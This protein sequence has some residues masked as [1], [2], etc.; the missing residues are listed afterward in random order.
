MASAKPYSQDASLHFSEGEI[1]KMAQVLERS[2]GFQ[3][4]HIADYFA[5]E[6]DIMGDFTRSQAWSDV[7]T[8]LRGKATTLRTVS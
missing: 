2:Y 5:H 6:H 3:A 8:I 1:E 4:A 7:A